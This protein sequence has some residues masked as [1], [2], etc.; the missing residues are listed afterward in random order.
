MSLTIVNSLR[1][2]PLSPILAGHSIHSYNK[3]L[4]KYDKFLALGFRK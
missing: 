1:E 2:H 4:A 3:F